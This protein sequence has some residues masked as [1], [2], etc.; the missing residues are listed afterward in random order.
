MA[1][2]DRLQRGSRSGVD[3]RVWTSAPGWM[4]CFRD[5]LDSLAPRQ[6]RSSVRRLPGFSSGEQGRSRQ[7]HL[8]SRK[9]VYHFLPALLNLRAPEAIPAVSFIGNH[10]GKKE[11]A[12]FEVAIPS[13]EGRRSPEWPDTEMQKLIKGNSRSYSGLYRRDPGFELSMGSSSGV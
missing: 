10:A 6:L 8:R 11:Q 1:T 5:P 9:P 2:S 3:L 7:K 4:P 12:R 13:R